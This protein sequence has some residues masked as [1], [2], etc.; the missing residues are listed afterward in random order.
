MNEVIIGGGLGV[1]VI[2]GLLSVFAV[3]RRYLHVCQPGEILVISGSSHRTSSGADVG[4]RVYTGGRVLQIPVLE[5]VGRMDARTILVELI[6]ANAYCKGGIPLNVNA[7]ANVKVSSDPSIVVNAVERFMGRDPSEIHRVARETLE[8]SLRGVLATLTP[9][10]VNEDRLKFANRVTE[11]VED[12]LARLGLHID[13]L[14][15]QNV[16]DD[17][18]YLGSIGREQIAIIRKQAE[19]AESDAKR[20]ADSVEADYLGKSRVVQELA[21]AVVQEKTNGLRQLIAEL[22]AEARSEEER[23]VAQADAARALAEQE[24]QEIRAELERL[25]LEVEVVLPSEAEK[26]AKGHLATG[27]AAYSVERGR[28]MAGAQ[29]LITEAWTDAGDDG[30]DI[31]L[32]QMIDTLLADVAKVVDQV[33]VKR[34]SLID[35][36]DGR[37]LAAY[38]S[39]YPSLVRMMLEEIR[40][41]TGV[42]IKGA[43]CREMASA[44]L[45]A[46]VKTAPRLSQTLFPTR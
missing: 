20:E 6:V 46:K 11:D 12:D 7:I 32:L 37:T 26:V 44:R 16:L 40:M 31:F 25:R 9:E 30:M 10:E 14:K 17:V 28:A 5:K 1:A 33:K 29:S 13:T 38:V 45:E 4:Y 23:A 43:M 34:V 15:V 35:G 24:L 27:E 21:R 22:D 18:S 19:V 36:G 41:T 2:V 42:D 39:S 3:I 8:G